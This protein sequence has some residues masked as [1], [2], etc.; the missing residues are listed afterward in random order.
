MNVGCPRAK[1]VEG[2]R[3]LKKAVEYLEENK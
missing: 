2:L 1:V 3:R